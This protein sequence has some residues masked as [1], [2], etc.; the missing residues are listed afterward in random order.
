[1]IFANAKPVD[2]NELAVLA[3]LAACCLATA[4]PGADFKLGFEDV[5]QL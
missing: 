4:V 2:S 5:K 3:A 1:M